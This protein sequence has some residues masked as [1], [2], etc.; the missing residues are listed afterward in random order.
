AGDD[1]RTTA[2]D[3]AA[4]RHAAARAHAQG[5]GAEAIPA[6]PARTEWLAPPEERLPSVARRKAESARALR[7]HGDPAPARDGRCGGATGRDRRAHAGLARAAPGQR[8]L[9]P[10]SRPDD[11][12]CTTTDRAPACSRECA[13]CR[14][15]C[16]YHR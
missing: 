10:W 16:L 2:Q 6:R 3:R 13:P 8:G 11:P 9:P 12:G 5:R 1:T 14:Q 7:R 4:T 15:T